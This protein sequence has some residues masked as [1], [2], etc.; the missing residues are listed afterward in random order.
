[1]NMPSIHDTAYIC[2][3][4]YIKTEN[5]SVGCYTR[6]NGKFFVHGRGTCDIGKYCAIGYNVTIITSNHKTNYANLQITLQRNLGSDYD[7][8]EDTSRRVL[9]HNNVWIGDSVVILPGVEI[10]NGAIIGANSVV[11]NSVPPYS[12]YSG[13]PA[14]E[15]KRRFPSNVASALDAIGWWNWSHPKI[16]RNKAFFEVDLLSE[17]SIELMNQVILP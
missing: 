15:I 13:C 14:R 12:V 4:A 9:I 2:S 6:L 16:L 17:N 11:T 3:D 1:M 7:F 8:L 10:H 5:F